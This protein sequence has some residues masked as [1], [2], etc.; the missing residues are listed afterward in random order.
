MNRVNGASVSYIL[1]ALH[2]FKGRCHHLIQNPG[3]KLI[4]VHD[5]NKLCNDRA[6]VSLSY[7]C[8]DTLRAQLG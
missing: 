2:H 1:C 7:P 3:T 5:H 4:V 8:E 6:F